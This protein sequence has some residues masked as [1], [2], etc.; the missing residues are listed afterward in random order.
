M[1]LLDKFLKKIIKVGRLV[2]TDHDGKVYEYG[3][4]VEG[5]EHGQPMHVRLTNKTAAYHIARY[6]EVGSGEAY[7][8]GWLVVDEPYDIPAATASLVGATRRAGGRIVAIGTT[9]VR[10]L[11]SAATVEGA[12]AAVHAGPGVAR[13]RIGPGAPPRIIDA[14]VTGTHEAGTSHFELLRALVDDAVLAEALARMARAG[15][16]THEFGDSMLVFRPATA[17]AASTSRPDPPRRPPRSSP[18]PP[19]G[20]AHTHR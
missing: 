10:A 1:W 2:I 19:S 12:V 4:G 17:T 15:Y 6:P 16:R 9:V 3:P 18:S 20:R 11:E 13:G 7:L 8:W 5:M 14:L